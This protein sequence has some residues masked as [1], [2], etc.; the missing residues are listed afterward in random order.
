MF[1]AIPISLLVAGVF[2]RIYRS[3]FWLW[4]LICM[5]SYDLHVLADA[6]TAGRGVM[7]FWPVTDVRFA[8]PVKI[9]Y[10]LQWGLGWFSLEHLWTILTE[11]LFGLIL[12]SAVN[13]FGK[14][15]RAT[16]Q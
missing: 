12:I 14:Q 1:V 7:M 11:S 16:S 10:G 9:F 4:F 15:R 5:I 3:N 6:M 8:S 13:C 2:Q